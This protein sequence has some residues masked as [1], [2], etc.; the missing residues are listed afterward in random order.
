MK[1]DP[2]PATAAEESTVASVQAE[3]FHGLDALRGFA[4][5]LG[6]VLHATLSFIPGFKYTGWPIV[7]NSSSPVLALAFFVI[8]LF[9]MPVFFLLAGFF[10][11]MQFRRYQARG[12]LKERTRRIL[13]PLLFGTFV[14]APLNVVL[15]A[16]V[17]MPGLKDPI[18]NLLPSRQ[19]LPIPLA[20]LWFL[21]V[22]YCFYLLF[23]LGRVVFRTL[24]K[25]KA[26]VLSGAIERGVN[27]I[28]ARKLEPVVL[29]LPVAVCLATFNQWHLWE[30]IP[31]PNTDLV[32]QLPTAVSYAVA[33]SFGWF[34]QKN[35]SVMFAWRER[36]IAY[37]A[38][39]AVVTAAIAV[40]GDFVPQS[41]LVDVN[42][43]L[44]LTA[45]TGTTKL[46]CALG[47]GLAS[48]LWTV[49]LIGVALRFWSG[50]NARRRYLADSSY[51]LYIIHLPLIMAL[52]VVVAD[53]PVNWALKYVLILAVAVPV[54]LLSY[55]YLVR[56]TWIGKLLNGRRYPRTRPADST[57]AV[58]TAAR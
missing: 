50:F 30:G 48:W 19:I 57:P 29:A 3:R 35:P 58:E 10:A 13:L 4:L 1:Q 8:H 49:G 17:V 9:R 36:W 23:L 7:D 56:A 12:F 32:P 46:L 27:W 24:V 18:V 15:I 47:Y 40:L 55:H 53:W 5:L 38:A 14:V 31:T 52:Q 51:W 22:L 34:L 45:L 39:A 42:G 25:D 33:F 2:G 37:L 20:H 11:R 43:T 54:L 6:V 44:S 16:V 28:C 21:W 26:A 41:S